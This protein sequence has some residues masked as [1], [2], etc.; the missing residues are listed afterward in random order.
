MRRMRQEVLIFMNV[1]N[2]N[3]FL[4]AQQDD[5]QVALKEIFHGK[6]RSHWMWYIFPQIEGLG[7]SEMS[8]KYCIH[9][10][11][12]AE[13][14]LN[15]PVLGKR[16]VAISKELLKLSEINPRTIF[17]TP[18][19]LKLRSSMTLFSC[20]PGGHEV[21]G[22]VLRKFYNGTKDPLTLALLK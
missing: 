5:Y 16:L 1:T 8:Q 9:D 7:F 22:E 12:E 19:D 6:K 4:E 2:F 10:I 18:D 3:H 20:V 15:H 11:R 13:Q 21:F 14:Y 17:G